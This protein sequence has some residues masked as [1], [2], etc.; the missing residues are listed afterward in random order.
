MSIISSSAIISREPFSKERLAGRILIISGKSGE[1]ITWME[2]PD[3]KETYFSPVV[4][5]LRNGTDV[6]VF[7]TGGETHGGTL[8]VI[9]LHHLYR[10]EIDLAL[11]IHKDSFKGTLFSLQSVA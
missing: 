11:Q 9:Q 5:T 1:V 7:G 4:Y 2:T 3:K 8:Y 6:V 10:G